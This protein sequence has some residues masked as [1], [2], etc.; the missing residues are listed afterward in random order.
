MPPM[1][2]E[3]ILTRGSFRFGRTRVTPNAR[4]AAFVK[5]ASPPVVMPRPIG[6]RRSHGNKRT[7]ALKAEPLILHKFT[8]GMHRRELTPQEIFLRLPR[9]FDALRHDLVIA[10]AV[11]LPATE[12]LEIR[13]R[14]GA[15]VT[16]LIFPKGKHVTR[17]GLR[18]RE[19]LA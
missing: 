15:Q 5:A 11:M 14:H 10:V 3:G 19:A 4:P 17:H 6:A 12:E 9:V 16:S 2:S 1:A 7:E 13:L 8:G 18:P